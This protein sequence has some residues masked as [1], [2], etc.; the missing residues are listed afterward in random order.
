MISQ[1]SMP[2][3]RSGTR[4]VWMSMPTPPL[5]AIS[6]DEEVM[7][8]APRSCRATNRPRCSSSR[9]TSSS[10]FSV[11][12]SPTWTEGRFCSSV[13]SNSWLASTLAPPMPSRPVLGAEQDHMVAHAGG[14]AAHDVLVPHQADGHGV[15][16]AVAGVGI[17]EVHLAAHGGDA[18]AVAVARRCRPPPARTGSAGGRE[19][20]VAGPPRAAEP[21]RPPA[22]PQA[23]RRRPARAPAGRA[24]SHRS[25]ASPGCRWAGRPW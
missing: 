15:H 17:L 8:A 23:R 20:P 12:G 6:L 9:Q 16:Q 24:R 18:H 14:L 25:A 5:A 21:P 10:F 4:S 11:K 3:S 7:P 13:S 22:R 2:G 1:G 19:P